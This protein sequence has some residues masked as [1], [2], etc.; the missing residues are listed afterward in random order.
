MAMTTTMMATEID[1]LGRARG[2]GQIFGIAG[3]QARVE[4]AD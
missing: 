2:I 4:V 3:T 1:P